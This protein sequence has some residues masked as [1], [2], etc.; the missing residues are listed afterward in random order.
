MPPVSDGP[1]G[2]PVAER[3]RLLTAATGRETSSVPRV[4][5]PPRA[6]PSIAPPPA[7]ARRTPVHRGTGTRHHPR[8]RTHARS[9]G[10]STQRILIGILVVATLGAGAWWGLQRGSGS[11]PVGNFV[12]A[13]QRFAAAARAI[14]ESTNQITNNKALNEWNAA[15]QVHLGEMDVA[16]VQMRRIHAASTDSA[17]RIAEA[18][19]ATAVQVTD[20]INDYRD[21]VNSGALTAAASAA[22]AIEQL[23]TELDKN[24]RA[25]KKL[26]GA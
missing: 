6:R 26:Q 17:A 21:Q 22:R 16:F 1:G 18:A 5:V 8:P 11:E 25:W 12:G 24:A 13:E 9:G 15:V 4:G 14:P 23:L 20:L 10:L 19:V 3:S 2:L 7:Y